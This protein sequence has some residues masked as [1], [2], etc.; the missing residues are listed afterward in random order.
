MYIP[1]REKKYTEENLLE[2]VAEVRQGYPVHK[3]AKTFQVPTETLQRWVI[4]DSN[5][6]FGGGRRPV[7]NKDEE[8]PIVV[9]LEQ[10]ARTGW[11]CDR[12]DVRTIVKTYLDGLGKQT[13]F[14]ENIPGEDWLASFALK[15]KDR[16]TTRKPEILTK[17]ST[18]Q[19]I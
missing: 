13:R 6:S 14:R 18:V 3:I 1:K 16:L 7:L 11:P 19:N 8:E 15:W 9:G 10:C 4:K 17:G 2:A 12:A 5:I